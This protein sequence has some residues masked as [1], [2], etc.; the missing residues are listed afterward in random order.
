MVSQNFITIRISRDDREKLRVV[1][2]TAGQSLTQLIKDY[3]NNMFELVGTFH[4][5]AN[6]CYELEDSD[7]LVI[8]VQGTSRTVVSHKSP[9]KKR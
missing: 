3:A 8:T 7:R 6:I 1:E 2:K 9:T 5:G 4:K